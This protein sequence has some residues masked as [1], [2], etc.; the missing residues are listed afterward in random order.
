MQVSQLKCVQTWL[1]VL[2]SSWDKTVE[3]VCLS[4]SCSLE[5]CL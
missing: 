2:D 4:V 5:E 1:V 3:G